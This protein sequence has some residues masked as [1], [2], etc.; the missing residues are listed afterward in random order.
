MA[1]PTDDLT[2]KTTVPAGTRFPK[3]LTLDQVQE[4]LNVGKPM[5]YT[6][7]KSGELRAAQFSGRGIWRVREDDLA[8]YIDAAYEKTAERI[9]TGQFSAAEDSED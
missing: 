2:N 4:I 1:K 3:M 5:V 6:L 8:A 9:A 7:V